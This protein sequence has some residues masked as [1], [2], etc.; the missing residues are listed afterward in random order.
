MG[1]NT[2]LCDLGRHPAFGAI[3]TPNHMALKCHVDNRLEA[4]YL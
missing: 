1:L 3:D 2:V 4:Y